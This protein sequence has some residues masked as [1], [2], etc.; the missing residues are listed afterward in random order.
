MSLATAL[1]EHADNRMQEEDDL[2][3]LGADLVGQARPT[4]T[5][6][7]RDQALIS[8]AGSGEVEESDDVAALE[9]RYSTAYLDAVMIERTKTR[10]VEEHKQRRRE[11]FVPVEE[12]IMSSEMPTTAS[13]KT[14]A[15]V[16]AQIDAG[17]NLEDIAMAEIVAINMAEAQ[18]ENQKDIAMVQGMGH[19]RSLEIEEALNTFKASIEGKFKPN[20]FLP[21]P[22]IIV[23]K[24]SSWLMFPI[25][26]GTNK[27]GMLDA[28][29]G[30]KHGFFS[31]I[32]SGL[33]MAE[34]QKIVNKMSLPEQRA[35]L[36]RAHDY[37]IANAGIFTDNQEDAN[38]LVALTEA[39]MGTAVQ[40]QAER[41][42]GTTMMA[43]DTVLTATFLKGAG[44]AWR[45]GKALIKGAPVSQQLIKG[46]TNTATVAV[47]EAAAKSVVKKTTGAAKDVK[48]T[49]QT[50]DA[51]GWPSK[52]STSGFS[53]PDMTVPVSPA[54]D[55]ADILTPE[56]LE[57]AKRKAGIVSDD[58]GGKPIVMNAD[59]KDGGKTLYGDLVEPFAR[60]AKSVRNK[61]KAGIAHNN[62]FYSG[63]PPW[64][65]AQK[66]DVIS[67]NTSGPILEA[68]LKDPKVAAGVGTTP[69]EIASAAIAPNVL[70]EAVRQ[71]ATLIMAKGTNV[72]S[73][74][75]RKLAELSNDGKMYTGEELERAKKS[76]D[77][78]NDS[79]VSK[80][81]HL[82]NKSEA[83]IDEG[84]GEV[85]MNYVFNAGKGRSFTSAR[86]A[87][88][89]V[90]KL[91]PEKLNLPAVL[92]YDV[93]EGVY[94]PFDGDPDEPGEFLLQALY[95]GDSS[96]GAMKEDVLLS[97]T[98]HPFT[99]NTDTSVSY[100]DRMSQAISRLDI[101]K[102]QIGK[103]FTEI[104]RPLSVL[105]S[106]ADLDAVWSALKEAELN[107]EDFTQQQ[108]NVKM[109]GDQARIS[110]YRA[111][112]K[113]NQ[114]LYEIRNGQY[115]KFLS[116][117]GYLTHTHNDGVDAWVKPIQDS[118]E[119]VSVWWDEAGTIVNKQTL[120]DE[121]IE[122]DILEGFKP[123][124][125]HAEVDG[126]MMVSPY[127]AVRKGKTA[128]Q[129]LPV[130]VLT[131]KKTY[132]SRHL[133][134]KYVIEKTEK[135]MV[136]GVK[137]EIT[138]V[139]AVSNNPLDALNHAATN[140]K[141]SY[142]RA[143][144]TSNVSDELDQMFDYQMLTNT[145][146]R[147][148]F[149][150]MD[151]SRQRS[152]LSPQESLDRVRNTMARNLVLNDFVQ[153]QTKK[154]MRTYGDLIDDQTFPWSGEL[155]LKASELNNPESE[156]LLAR[157]KLVRQRIQLT[158]GAH[159]LQ[160]GEKI[161]NYLL[162]F[163]EWLSRLGSNAAKRGEAGLLRNM[164]VKSINFAASAA[165]RASG[166]NVVTKAKSLA[167][168]SFIIA[169]PL[170]QLVMQSAS[171]FMYVGL[172]HGTKYMASTAAGRDL[173]FFMA[174]KAFQNSPDALKTIIK[175]YSKIAGVSEK[176]A[177]KMWDDFADGATLESISGH[178]FQEF[179]LSSGGHYR[180]HAGTYA[181]SEVPNLLTKT[182]HSAKGGFDTAVRASSNVGFE[183]GEAIHRMS[184][185]LAVR[186]KH[187]VNGTI[188]AMDAQDL[189]TEA[190]RVSGN[191]GAFSKAAFQEGALG[192]PF[193]FMSHTTRML[194]YMMPHTKLTSWVSSKTFSEKEKAKIGLWQFAMF[195]SKGVGLGTAWSMF[196]ADNG[197][198]M[199]PLVL[200]AL[201]GG[202]FEMGM[203]ALV[204]G[205]TGTEADVDIS[206]VMG[207]LS[208]VLNDFSVLFNDGDQAAT[209]PGKIYKVLTDIAVG[210]PTGFDDFL[211][212]GGAAVGKAGGILGNIH[213]I[214]MNPMLDTGEK[215][216]KQV[217]DI[218][219]M[220][221]AIDNVNRARMM[222]AMGQVVTQ[223]GT[224]VVQA[225][226]AD[227]F[228]K[229]ALGINPKGVNNAFDLNAEIQ[230]SS[231][232][233]VQPSHKELSTSGRDTAN[234]TF[235]TLMEI[236][237]GQSS[238]E[239]VL[240]RLEAWNAVI[241]LMYP[242]ATDR[243]IYQAAFNTEI[244]KLAGD[245]ETLTDTLVN[246][247]ANDFELSHDLG[248]TR[249]RNR[250]ESLGP[251]ES[252]DAVVEII[253]NMI[254]KEE[255]V[256]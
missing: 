48:L 231:S 54:D 8:V 215:F 176:D 107:I 170:R 256:N 188:G 18:T 84:T 87:M 235:N 98:A 171:S 154:W 61:K 91:P 122:L 96:S 157:A 34:A 192:L 182:L 42:A 113:F 126:S 208:G 219:K 238:K 159:D 104:L 89:F 152:V 173:S 228:F 129:S 101:R 177:T 72:I 137:R 56:R 92:K 99:N 216:E 166:H 79:L 242:D 26:G 3:V 248:W 222:G 49:G 160:V 250:I 196:L 158:T 20:A 15:D 28:M 32:A 64:S 93:D 156:R 131:N 225:T 150:E 25:S 194:S 254:N 36:T 29:T 239:E 40:L 31:S 10:L 138:K 161:Q 233:W 149:H 189:A 181:G 30:K 71:G 128:L 38:A 184:A 39:L 27:T 214:W 195:G 224:P 85:S 2:P 125:A 95:K 121:G 46:L 81:S 206:G 220:V 244:T 51:G 21:Y 12:A 143:K 183:G 132:L 193:Q 179:A 199:D 109:G 1:E 226:W 47:G 22:E 211:G 69:Q 178:Q 102:A 204:E 114:T 223:Y 19:L 207:P 74:Y 241:H 55:I 5:K 17:A 75:A 247:M 167:H 7:A 187:I 115:R 16:R 175:R 130:Q 148:E 249:I 246:A 83:F 200:E 24:L 141:Y 243:D 146:N 139:I 232:G 255:E 252:K 11:A 4:L 245:R 13:F 186:N 111:V 110:A 123:R 197:V 205:A 67:P 163:G 100:I 203:I 119:V 37:I 127:T 78:V 227:A 210:A 77:T 53:T 234:F 65:V 212:A 106:K 230:G 116:N 44:L 172:E 190:L 180:N 82:V 144:E 105:K 133:E 90:S 120:L 237:N 41:I 168:L 145:K 165:T 240:D 60:T 124:T 45:G 80:E 174:A 68:G 169:N 147:L 97:S 229:G 198:E 66:I 58:L 134:T 201:E 76:L 221:P 142:R 86:E 155:K 6:L 59:M 236:N 151:V 153:Y 191:M 70:G 162:G 117:K 112:R 202:L 23:E 50:Y 253:N 43:I 94:K 63:L 217:R 88:A 33:H 118:D 57:E 135:A 103:V 251:S 108:L 218:V 136:N 35:A 185:Y 52:Y 14:I 140:P 209:P 73:D 213:R 62:K 164:K 9:D